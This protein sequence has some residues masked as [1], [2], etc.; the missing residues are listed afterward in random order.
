MPLSRSVQK[1]VD[2]LEVVGEVGAEDGEVLHRGIR[3]GAR[4][5]LE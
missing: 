4:E 2:Q 1:A 3:V 5:D